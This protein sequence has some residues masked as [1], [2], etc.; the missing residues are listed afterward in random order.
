MSLI[1]TRLAQLETIQQKYEEIHRRNPVL[2]SE[3][4]DKAK[5]LRRELGEDMGPINRLLEASNIFS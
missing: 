4:A 5:K 3:L 1:D 2:A